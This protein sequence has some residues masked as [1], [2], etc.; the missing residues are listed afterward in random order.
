MC[1]VVLV[2]CPRLGRVGAQYGA[3]A[4]TDVARGILPNM[5]AERHRGRNPIG[6]P[7]NVPLFPSQAHYDSVFGEMMDRLH[8]PRSINDILVTNDRDGV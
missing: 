3:S 7:V 8:Y 1:G 4:R 6:E 5:E 2:L